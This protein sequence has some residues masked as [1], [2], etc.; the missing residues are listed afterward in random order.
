MLGPGCGDTNFASSGSCFGSSAG[1]SS[2]GR[3][4][5]GAG[6]AGW[7]GT[8]AAGAGTIGIAAG[9]CACTGA[10]TWIGATGAGTCAGAGAGAIWIAAWTG[11]GAGTGAGPS[12]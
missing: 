12:A 6:I 1:V 10:R 4:C 3:T 5:D 2:L 11:F 7:T 9:I 8:V